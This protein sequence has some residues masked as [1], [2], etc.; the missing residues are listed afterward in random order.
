MK[1][2]T[3]D[4]T[5][6]EILEIKKADKILTKYGVPCLTCP[7][8]KFELNELKIGQVAEMYKLDLKNILKEL[9]NINK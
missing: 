4:T 7:M 6:S 5:L 2:I 9:N 1:K 3:K 8:A